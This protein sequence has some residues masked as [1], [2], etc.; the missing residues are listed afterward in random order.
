MAVVRPLN[1]RVVPAW[2]AFL[3]QALVNY[4]R[5]WLV[6]D[7]IAGLTLAAVAIP[8]CMGYA[9]IAGAPVVT[10]IYTMLLP[11]IAFAYV[12][13]SRHLSV[14]ADS[15][16]AAILFAGLINLAEPLSAAWMQLAGQ[17]AL[18]TAALLLLA[19]VARLGFLADFLSRTV[20]VGFLGG[21]GVSLVIGQMPD[22]LGIA[23]ADHDFLPRLVASLEQLPDAH[24]PTLLVAAA[25]FGVLVLTERYV[26]RAPGALIAVVLAI[27]ASFLLHFGEHGIAVVGALQTGIPSLVLPLPNESTLPQLLPIS[28]SMFLVVLAQSAATSRSFAQRHDEHVEEDKDLIGLSLANACAAITSTFVVNGSPTKTAVVDAAGGKSQVAQLVTAGA[29]VVVLLFATGPIAQLPVAALAAL[30]AFIGVRLVDI[31]ALRG[32]LACRRVTFAVAMGTMLAVIF[33]G[34]ERGIFVAIGLSILDHLQRE[35][36]PKDIV[37]VHADDHWFP[38]KARPGVESAAG[39]LVYRFEAPLFFA[40]ADYFSSRV[41]LLVHSAP[42]PIRNVILDMVAVSDVDYTAGL[43]LAARLQRLHEHGIRV[44]VAQGEDIVDDLVR[45]GII[46]HSDGVATYPTLQDAMDA[47]NAHDQRAKA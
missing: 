27:G 21:V 38:Q 24:L 35:Y 29:T 25:V 14:G 31:H 22:L 44:A 19:R 18:L 15:A 36:R 30:V 47:L 37:M 10:G 41:S 34:V 28:A 11:V 42:H 45:R 12:G 17:A 23:V 3:P 26:P 16:T 6:S 33:L 20:L 7:V 39:L 9:A 46:N 1:G 8:E 40:N 2:R 32:I 5:S 13:S 4:D 43:V